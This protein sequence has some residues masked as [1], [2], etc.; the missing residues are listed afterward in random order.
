MSNRFVDLKNIE[1]FG[2]QMQNKKFNDLFNIFKV[3]RPKY[4][5][6]S[7]RLINIF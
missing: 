4:K 5:I 6:E 3:Q 1:Y 7:L 2:D